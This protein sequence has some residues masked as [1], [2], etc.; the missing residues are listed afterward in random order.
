MK[1]RDEFYRLTGLEFPNRDTADNTVVGFQS[2]Y[3]P[4]MDRVILHKKDY[5]ILQRYSTVEVEPD[6][7]EDIP[8]D[9]LEGLQG[10]APA[11]DGGL[12]Y[13]MTDTDYITFSYYDEEEDEY[14]PIDFNNKDYFV[15][16]S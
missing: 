12:Y 13:V 10:T 9:L 5:S 14:V 6:V 16:Q 2:V 8:Y 7:F 11:V 3:D 1:F 4:A 15:N